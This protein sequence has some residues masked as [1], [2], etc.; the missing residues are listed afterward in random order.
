V[1]RLFDP[2]IFD[3]LKV[4][5]EGAIYDKDFEGAWT[6]IGR[7]DNIDLATMSREFLIH[8][9]L[10]SKSKSSCTWHLSSTVEQLASELTGE[11]NQSLLG[12]STRIEFTVTF[13]PRK[14][15]LE[16]VYNTISNIWR[17][18]ELVSTVIDS[19]PKETHSKMIVS[20]EFNRIIYEE[21]IDDLLTMLTYMERTL[22]ELYQK[23]Y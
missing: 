12:C 20:V 23:G 17:E 4:V 6:V 19:Y 16:S 15:Q 8:F 11:E 18:R 5:I 14:K 3:N 21:D 1:S 2:T 7:R 9:Q 22:N 13:S 10:N